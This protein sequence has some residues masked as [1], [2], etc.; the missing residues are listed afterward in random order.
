[1][2]LKSKLPFGKTPNVPNREVK[3][4]NPSFMETNTGSQDPSKGDRNDKYDNLVSS[5]KE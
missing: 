2:R 1:M 4:Q 3:S 5:V